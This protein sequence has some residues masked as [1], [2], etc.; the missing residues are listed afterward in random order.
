MLER[1]GGLIFGDSDVVSVNLYPQW[2]HDKP[3][4]VQIDEKLEEIRTHGGDNKPVI[5]SEI[6]A[7]AIYGYHDPFGQAKW[8]EERQCAILRKQIEGVLANE[9]LSGIFLW[10]FADC[11]ICDEWFGSRPRSYNNKGVVDEFRRPKMSYAVVKE[12]F[13]R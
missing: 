1:P 10:Q 9:S 11:R 3:V 7:G 12:L 13:R 5:I 4:Q 6:G 2:Y 8:S